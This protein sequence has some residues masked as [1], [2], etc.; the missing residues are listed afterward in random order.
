MPVDP[1][2]GLSVEEAQLIIN[3]LGERVPLS[4]TAQPTL[5]Q[6]GPAVAP[7]SPGGTGVVGPAFTGGGSARGT[8]PAGDEVTGRI[9]SLGQKALEQLRR[10]GA[11]DDAPSGA[12]NPE[13]EQA[14]QTQRAGERARRI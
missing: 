10:S 2:S 1:T 4:L 9:A 7:A 5:P 14:Y 13:T 6:G 3:E 8:R 11:F 12:R